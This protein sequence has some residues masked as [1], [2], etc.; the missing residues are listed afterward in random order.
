[1]ET[2]VIADIFRP[3]QTTVATVRAE[4]GHFVPQMTGA[5]LVS[6]RT[7]SHQSKMGL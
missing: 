3:F 2:L 5:A 6:H 7:K 4:I 1:M